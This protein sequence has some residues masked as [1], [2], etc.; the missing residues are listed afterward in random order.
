MAAKDPTVREAAAA[1]ARHEHWHGPDDPR[2]VEARKALAEARLE[3]RAREL[4][5]SAP[6]LTDEQRIRLA[7]IFLAPG[8]GE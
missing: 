4:A 5:T 7:N 6:P 2:T 8:G 3:A 1:A